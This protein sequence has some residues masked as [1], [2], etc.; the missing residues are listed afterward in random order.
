MAAPKPTIQCPRSRCHTWTPGRSLGSRL[1]TFTHLGTWLPA[2]PPALRQVALPAFPR[3]AD[4]PPATVVRPIGPVLGA[5]APGGAETALTS[6]AVRSL[7]PRER[8]AIGRCFWTRSSTTRGFGASGKL[9]LLGV[10]KRSR[11]PQVAGPQVNMLP[12]EGQLGAPDRVFLN[13]ARNP[14]PRRGWRRYRWLRAPSQSVYRAIS[15][16]KTPVEASFAGF[17]I[18]SMTGLLNMFETR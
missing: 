5:P 11:C 2:Q 14:E 13:W 4:P 12:V 1:T 8:G 17:R 16:V 6:W 15:T 18:I 9:S 7:G 10:P 3:F